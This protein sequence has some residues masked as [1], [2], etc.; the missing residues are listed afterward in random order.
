MKSS[1]AN[2]YGFEQIHEEFIAERDTLAQ[3]L[4]H[5]PSGAR[6]LSMQNHDEN[7]VFGIS[8]RTPPSDSTG[9]AHI[10]EHCVLGGSKKY[11]LKE[12]FVELVKGSLKTFLNAMT[13]PDKTVYPVASPNTKDFYNLVD[14]YLDA[15]L[16]PLI[17]PFHL[18]QEGWH[19][20]LDKLGEPMRYKG[21]VFN[22]MKGAYSS[23]DGVFARQS[24]RSLFPDT[25]YGVDSGGDPTEIP[26]LSY[27]QFKR[28]HETFYHPSNAYIYFY[29]DDDP[30]KRLEMLAAYLDE[31]PAKEVSSSVEIQPR[32]QAPRTMRYFYS[33]DAKE[34]QEENGLSTD[35][36][37]GLDTKRGSGEEHE[38]DSV[39]TSAS[40]LSMMQ[41]DNRD[42]AMVRMNWLLP[43][44]EEP[45][46][47][48][49]LII[50]SSALLG[51]PASP[52]RKRLT[53]SGLGENVIGGGV[54]LGGR[55]MTFAVGLKGVEVEDI[56]KA[57]A[58]IWE[59]LLEIAEE[60]I[61]PDVVT[62]AVNTFEFH[63][64]ENNTYST[65]RG[66]SMMLNA[67]NSWLYDRD[68]L[69]F[70][71]YEAPL[72]KA[73]A[74]LQDDPL[75]L[76][77]LLQNFIIDNTHR[78]TTTI[79]PQ[80]GLDAQKEAE[81]AERLAD[82]QATMSDETLQHIIDETKQ[83]RQLQQAQDSP[84]LLAKLP[85]L[86]L[87]DLDP[88]EK[89]LP[90]EEMRRNG[91]SV[92]F[93]DLFTSGIV[94]LDLAFDM[95]GVPQELLPYFSIFGRLLTEMG[96]HNQDYVQLLNRIGAHTG[97]IYA[98]DM[99]RPLSPSSTNGKADYGA[100][101][102]VRGKSTLD[103][104]G[105]LFN[106]LREILLELKLDDRT[107]LS[108][109]VLK[110]K[111]QAE[112]SLIP[113]GHGVVGTRLHSQL[114]QTGW[115]SEQIDGVTNLFFLR[116]LASRI[117]ND[118][119]SV[120]QELEQIRKTLINREALVCNVTL[121]EDGWNRLSPRLDEFIGEI[122][123]TTFQRVHWQA[124]L[125]QRNEGLL[126]PAQVNYVGKGANLYGLGYE[127]HGSILPITN[128]LRTSWL[129]SNIRVQGGAY[130]AF[131]RFNRSSGNFTFLSYRDPNLLNTL[132]VYDGTADFLRGELLG[133]DEL[134]RSIIGAISSWDGYQLP[135]AKGYS[136]MVYHL[137]GLTLEQRQKTRTEILSTT[138]T[139]FSNFTHVLDEVEK[140]GQVVVLG[141]SSAMNEANSVRSSESQSDWL[142][143]LKVM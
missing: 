131:C 85:R 60:G 69:V 6:L 55:E 35:G 111:A 37:N 52:L 77:T 14:V 84:E 25:I 74:R 18:Q 67:L 30:L 11:P 43:E 70:L 17:T 40:S 51:T 56:Q 31:F 63:L 38:S 49:S 123:G 16:N 94:Y 4:H 141:S 75:Y 91:A 44:G 3:L 124:E 92:L 7:K 21:V 50:L 118:W 125:R 127:M 2:N 80:P 116:N 72:A 12:P 82:I 54:G 53:D 109:I 87:A 1:Q 86:G 97:G 76:Q 73:K 79:E 138:M 48:M 136:S 29:G 27:D 39:G 139:D 117:E 103:E 13:Y 129:W 81:E 130:G 19:Y 98:Y 32:W 71:R 83:L 140:K 121:D 36:I 119:S 20:E 100:W 122:P 110:A 102:I 137:T 104:S 57:E 28:F 107:R 108:Q 93:H 10:L 95:R 128:Y 112:S 24:S 59:T 62:A 78:T 34:G 23:P 101:F 126:I 33:V 99:I 58:T 42:K 90:I 64:R 142:E 65:P 135:D 5:T 26:N 66:L 15:V 115:I 22:E 41:G 106:I 105:E 88:E 46:L 96:T 114:H 61:E 45:E 113:G 143:L 89:A 134:V 133:E 8:F 68:P 9:V 120:H 132:N 47:V